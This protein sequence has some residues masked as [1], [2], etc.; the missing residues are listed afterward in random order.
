M[1]TFLLLF[2]ATL[3]LGCATACS[4]FAAMLKPDV[5]SSMEESESVG[6]GSSTEEESGST[7]E[8]SASTEDED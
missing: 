2:V 8:E 5:S 1:K 3:F 4:D 7:E 6:D